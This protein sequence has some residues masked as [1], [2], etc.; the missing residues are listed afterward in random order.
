MEETGLK[1]TPTLLRN[2]QMVR[3]SLGEQMKMPVSQP[4]MQRPFPRE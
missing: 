3:C 4:R 2:K 1:V